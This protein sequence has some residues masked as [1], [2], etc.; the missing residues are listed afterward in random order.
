MLVFHPWDSLVGLRKGPPRSFLVVKILCS[1]QHWFLLTRWSDWNCEGLCFLWK[2]AAGRGLIDAVNNVMKSITSS[3]SFIFM[4]AFPLARV[5]GTEAP[6]GLEAHHDQPKSLIVLLAPHQDGTKQGR[7]CS[8]STW[9]LGR[10]PGRFPVG[11]VADR[12]FPVAF[13]SCGWTNVAGISRFGEVA[14][15][16]GICNFPN[17]IVGQTGCTIYAATPTI[18]G[19]VGG[20]YAKELLWAHLCRRGLALYLYSMWLSLV[21]LNFVWWSQTKCITSADECAEQ[22]PIEKRLCSGAQR[23]FARIL[24]RVMNAP[25]V[26]WIYF[27]VAAICMFVRTAMIA[28]KHERQLIM[29]QLI[30]SISNCVLTLEAESNAIIKCCVRGCGSR[31]FHGCGSRSFYQLLARLF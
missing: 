21:K 29:Q 4:S 19:G 30:W 7:R 10:P 23:R 12:T 13:W 15:H 11:G 3:F 6:G 20:Y 8:H 22:S 17:Y 2:D 31:S 26:Y 25:P 5:A 16:G 9:S 18:S 1:T 28:R 27:L 14:R 24:L